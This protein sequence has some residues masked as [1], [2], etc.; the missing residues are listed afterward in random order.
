MEML[1]NCAQWG[2]GD[3][4]PFQFLLLLHSKSMHTASLSSSRCSSEKGKTKK[5]NKHT[6]QPH[7]YPLPHKP[8]SIQKRALMISEDISNVCPYR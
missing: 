1:C 8:N 7:S 3:I 4:C 5:S 6:P 2:P